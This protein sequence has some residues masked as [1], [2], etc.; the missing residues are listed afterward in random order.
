[1]QARRKIIDEKLEY[2]YKIGGR[3]LKTNGELKEWLTGELKEKEISFKDF[4]E[5]IN[6]N[7]TGLH[8]KFNYTKDLGFNLIS[9]IIKKLG[10][11][12]SITSNNDTTDL[13]IFEV[14]HSSSLKAA[15]HSPHPLFEDTAISKQ[16]HPLSTK[17]KDNKNNRVIVR[18]IKHS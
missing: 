3:T 6:E 14:C 9:K 12:I 7:P 5:E 11:N 13:E 1:M 4:A 16:E 10:Y 18:H 8:D 2:P 15:C 17:R